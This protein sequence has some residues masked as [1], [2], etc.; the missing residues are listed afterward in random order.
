MKKLL[1]SAICGIMGTAAFAQATITGT[2]TD[3]NAAAVANHWV[4]AADSLNQSWL[5]SAQTDVSGNYTINIPAW[6]NTNIPIDVW[7]NENCAPGSIHNGYFYTGSNITSDFV[8]CYVAPQPV[9]EGT[10]YSTNPSVGDTASMVYLIEEHYDSTANSW[11]LTALDST[12]TDG[13][14]HYSFNSPVFYTYLLVKAALL[15][16]SPDYANYLPTYFSSSLL[17]SGAT[18][19]VPNSVNDIQL[20]GG[21]NPGGPAFVGGDVLQGAN[22]STAVGDPLS[23]KIIILTTGADVPVA[24]T[25]SDAS[26]QFSFP[27]LA[28]GTYKLFGDVMGKDNPALSITLDAAH[29]SISNIVFEEHSHEFEGHIATAVVNVNSKLSGISLYPNPAVNNINILG[30]ETVKGAK[31]VT[32]SSMNGAVIYNHTYNDGQAAA[33]PVSALSHG[34]Y[35]LNVNTAEGVATFKVVK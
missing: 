17:W 14:G 1:L 5:D 9:I 25:Y 26:G 24:Y 7:T 18:S 31:T 15:P 28:Y 32:L 16:F 30:L 34:I 19:V 23:S 33:V 29:P 6:V 10:V 3:N 20:I 11:I 22:K 13:A 27:N 8:L 4:Y 21:V 2:V 12:Q 35:M